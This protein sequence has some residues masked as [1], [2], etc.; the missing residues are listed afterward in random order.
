MAHQGL[1]SASGPPSQGEKIFKFHLCSTHIFFFSPVTEEM[2]E[3]NARGQRVEAS[4]LYANARE[5]AALCHS[6]AT[7]GLTLCTGKEE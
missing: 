4:W 7:Y 6:V 1:L 3:F 5:A 2:S